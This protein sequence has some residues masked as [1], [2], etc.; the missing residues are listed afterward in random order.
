MNGEL[1]TEVNET[2]DEVN[3]TFEEINQTFEGSADVMTLRPMRSVR[4]A[5]IAFG[6]VCYAAFAVLYFTRPNKPILSLG[7]M[8][9][10]V[11]ALMEWLFTVMA[12]PG[13]GLAYF[14]GIRHHEENPDFA[15]PDLLIDLLFVVAIAWVAVGNGIHLTAKLDEQ[16]ISSVKDSQ[17]L[18]IRADFH[19]TRQ[20]MG[21]IL[22]HIGWQVLFS[23]LMLGQLKR[24]YSGHKPKAVIP[25]FGIIFGLLFAQGAIAGTCTHFGFVL[26]AISC[27]GFWYL[28]KKSELEPGEVPILTFFFF[29]QVTFLLMMVGYWSV[30]R[31]GIV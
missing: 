30:T 24:P 31:L 21:H 5:T 20:V 19:W 23:A 3:G 8:H 6:L 16:M 10:T 22:P 13:V 4:I 28:G 18:G 15:F 7:Q 9:F 11:D 2:F 26:T 12:I 17:W 29:S 27:L 1:S 14:Y 25:I